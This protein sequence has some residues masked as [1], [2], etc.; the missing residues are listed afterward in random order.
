MIDAPKEWKSRLLRCNP[1]DDDCVICQ[2]LAGDHREAVLLAVI[3][4]LDEAA[5]SA[6]DSERR[7][8][9]DR[10]T[11]CKWYRADRKVVWSTECG[12]WI[13]VIDGDHVEPYCPGCGRLVTRREGAADESANDL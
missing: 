7:L 5:G 10:A 13:G 12:R 3:E 8:V 2:F 11:P 4:A 1:G 6:E 9:R